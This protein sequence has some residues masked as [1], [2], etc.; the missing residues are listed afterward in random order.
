MKATNLQE[1]LRKALLSKNIF[2]PGALPAIPEVG[3]NLFLKCKAQYF[4]TFLNFT[5]KTKSN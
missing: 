4:I 1:V 2:T 3:T 5:S